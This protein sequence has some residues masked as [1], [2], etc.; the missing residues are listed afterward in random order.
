[1]PSYRVATGNIS[2]GLFDV[3]GQD[4]G[5]RAFVGHAGLANS[6]GSQI[7]AD[8]RV[9]DM[10][11]P[12]HGQAAP[13]HIRADVVGSAVLTDD[14]VQ[15]IKTF[16]DRHENEHRSLL[17]L[18][19]TERIAAA[20]KMYIICPHAMPFYEEDGRYARMRF[21]CAG[22]VLEAYRKARVNLLE[23][24]ALPPVDMAI[25]R[26]CYPTQIRLM[27]DGKI[28]PDD[29]GLG[30]NGPW[31]VLLCGYLFH[32]LNRDGVAAR[33]GTYVPSADQRYFT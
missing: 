18:S 1:L 28:S 3:V 29:L 9:L 8:V 31:Q 23:P 32:A 6:A 13:G 10:G 4:G 22:F 11:P 14:D 27:E 7:A 15:K 30:G 12:L 5:E 2:L 17:L 21:S 24:K 20:P 19:R 33:R 26:V 16:I 25:I